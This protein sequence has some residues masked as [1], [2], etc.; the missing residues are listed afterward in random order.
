MKQYFSTPVISKLS[1]SYYMCELYMETSI[2]VSAMIYNYNDIIRCI[3]NS[4]QGSLS[5]LMY[6][7]DIG[8]RN[9]IS[10]LQH[11]LHINKHQ[12]EVTVNATVL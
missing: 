7:G 12:F 5:I 4:Q 3:K 2:K 1:D 6:D 9:Y 11:H 10:M 8:G